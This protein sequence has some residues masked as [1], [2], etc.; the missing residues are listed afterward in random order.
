MEDGAKKAVGAA[1]ALALAVGAFV[2]RGGDDVARVASH[3]ARYGDDVAEIGARSA[4]DIAH[5][6][7]DVARGTGFGDEALWGP[8]R[9]GASFGGAAFD[10]IAALDPHGVA[11]MSEEA[12]T[13]SDDAIEALA[14]LTIETASNLTSFESEGDVRSLPVLDAQAI[15]VAP[16]SARVLVLGSSPMAGA[17]RSPTSFAELDIVLAAGSFDTMDLLVLAQDESGMVRGAENERPRSVEAVLLRAAQHGRRSILLACPSSP[18]SQ[19]CLQR[20]IEVARAASTPGMNAITER[21]LLARDRSPARAEI[22]L[23]RLHHGRN[24]RPGM[25][26]AVA[27]RAD[28]P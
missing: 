5:G 14:D 3:G 23:Y 25:R 11:A 16:S 12:P 10:D 28:A 8:N 13:L 20:G 21:I 24:E 15:R 27:P 9:T 26:L 1:G 2:A 22:A 17:D 18:R 19:Q 7:D 4:D 6:G